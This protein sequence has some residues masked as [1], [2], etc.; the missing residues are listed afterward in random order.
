[1]EAPTWEGA[2]AARRITT[3]MERSGGEAR[4][5]CVKGHAP[6]VLTR[7]IAV[8]YDEHVNRTTGAD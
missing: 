6:T 8:G 2:V 3:G 5:G 1:M 4:S 7:R